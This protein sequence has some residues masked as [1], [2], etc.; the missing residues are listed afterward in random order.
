MRMNKNIKVI[1]VDDESRIRRGI[2]KLII[3][4]GEDWEIV[5]TYADGQE[6]LNDILANDIFFDVLFTDMKMPSMSG[7]E[8]LSR[9]KEKVTHTYHSV[10]I[11]GYDDF[12]FVQKA[13]RQGTIDYLLKPIDRHEMQRCLNNIKSLV[14]SKKKVDETYSTNVSIELA[15]KWI[16][17]NLG[18]NITIEKISSKV[19]MNPSYFSEYFKRKTGE[20]VLD[21]VTRKRMEK[22]ILLLQTTN[23]KIYEVS[24]LTGYTD[25]KYF[26]KLFKK[27]YG[28][29]PSQIRHQ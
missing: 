12:S 15:T 18:E 25:T 23:I 9:L 20:T 2:E 5:K 17:D 3:S 21:F 24:T 6:C 7:L 8:L 11:S 10:V 4:N 16:L 1:I 28:V 14:L 26:S 13:M 27:Y 19:F 22:A 29:L